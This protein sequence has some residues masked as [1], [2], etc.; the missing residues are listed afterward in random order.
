MSEQK[1]VDWIQ[2]I[3]DSEPENGAF[4]EKQKEDEK[5]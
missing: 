5:E 3:I 2:E 4:C 1:S